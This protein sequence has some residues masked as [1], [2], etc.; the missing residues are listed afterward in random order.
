MCISLGRN[1]SD[2]ACK[3][4]LNLKL[5]EGDRPSRGSGM[6]EYGEK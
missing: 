6:L 1:A 4:M 3:A 2:I 5:G